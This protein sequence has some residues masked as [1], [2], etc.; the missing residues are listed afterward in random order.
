MNKYL[1]LPKSV[2]NQDYI[3]TENQIINCIGSI[4]K[5]NILIGSNN[6]RK[7]RFTRSLLKLPSLNL[8]NINIQEII[9][10]IKFE[11]E[12]I[13]TSF[14]EGSHVTI[15]KRTS[16]NSVQNI[17]P[18][19]TFFNKIKNFIIN[20]NSSSIEVNEYYIN[21]VIDDT[22]NS[23][24]SSDDISTSL[25][26]IKQLNLALDVI[27][28]IHE[29]INETGGNH[30]SYI[31]VNASSNKVLKGFNNFKNLL[32]LTTTLLNSKIDYFSP[33]KIYIPTLRSAVSF[34]DK[35][36]NNQTYK[37][38][39]D[40]YHSTICKHYQIKPEDKIEVFTGMDLFNKIKK[41]RNSRREI[42][43]RFRNFEEFL[44]NNFFDGRDIDIIALEEDTNEEEHIQIYIK[45]EEDREIHDLGDGVQSL[46]ILLYPIFM[47]EKDSWFFI[48][49][50]E[51]NL[52][53]GLQHIFLNTLLANSFIK[54]KN[55]TFFLTSHSN[56]LLNLS[57]SHQKSISIFSFEKIEIENKSPTRISQ[58]I[59]NNTKVLD[60]LGVYNA[61]VFMSNCS[62]WVEGISD[63]RYLQAFL[64][65]Y[66][67]TQ[68]KTYQEDLHYSF[69]E[70]A[71]SNLQH[72]LF[73]EENSNDLNKIKAHFLSNRIFILADQDSSDWKQQKHEEYQKWQ[74]EKF[75]YKTTGALE[76][77]NT[78]SAVII[79][80]IMKKVLKIESEIVDRMEFTELRYR[81]E[82]LGKFL[83]ERLRNKVPKIPKVKETNSNTL[84]TDYKN[85]FSKFVLDEVEAHNLTWKD[86]SQN[87]DA[88]DITITLF[89][90]IQRHNNN[91]N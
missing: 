90:F 35:S 51:I 50:P 88:R 68:T 63:R 82:G 69:F 60:L 34:Y 32:D 55:L 85:K 64:L 80:R 22:I 31:R 17:N 23:L 72:Y 56:H 81:Q 27:V 30:T 74:S 29:I 70:Y 73:N 83:T 15:T 25:I 61:S 67:N 14:D 46:I 49:E 28:N 13:F 9:Q 38:N 39:R 89:E 4:N 5:L 76:I 57:L 40:I 20:F 3:N 52:H 79:N 54:S 59:G 75:L 41:N 19:Y 16:A 24:N 8:L 42:R 26:Q 21:K 11:A 47:A 84:T 77:E 12:N 37:I 62:I 36:D 53:P 10:K 78:L 87:Q 33:K 58:V 7:S 45:G 91:F 2:I 6:S 18:D 66:S 44:S 65:A 1:Y 43:D 48:E 71:G 86:I